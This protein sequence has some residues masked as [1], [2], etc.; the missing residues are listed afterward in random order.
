[1]LDT[2]IFINCI[3]F[4]DL[5]Y[6]PPIRHQRNQHYNSP[7]ISGNVIRRYF[8]SNPHIH[9]RDQ[10]NIDQGIGSIIDDPNDGRRIHTE[11][12]DGVGRAAVFNGGAGGCSDDHGVLFV[13]VAELFS[14][15]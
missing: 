5:L 13:G 12:S 8:H 9:Q 2:F 15:D 7:L 14:D 10:F 6:T 11:F 1:M 4:S 3:M